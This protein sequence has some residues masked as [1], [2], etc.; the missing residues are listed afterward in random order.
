M[1][2]LYVLDFRMREIG[3]NG[4]PLD[5]LNELVDW[6]IFRPTLS[7]IREKKRKSRASRK[8]IEVVLM[9][10]ILVLQSL[11][12]LSNNVTE[13]QI[14]GRLFFIGFLGL[15][16]GDSV[17]NAKTIWLFRKKFKENGLLSCLFFE[18][19]RFLKNNDFEL[20]KERLLDNT[21]IVSIPRQKN[22]RKE[23]GQIKAED[24]FEDRSANKRGHNDINVQWA[25]KN[26]KSYFEYKN[27]NDY[28]YINNKY[29]WLCKFGVIHASLYN[30]RYL[31]NPLD[32]VFEHNLKKEQK[33]RKKYKK[34]FYRSSFK[35]RKGES[36]FTL[37][38]LMI[39][40]VLLGILAAIALPQYNSYRGR[41][42]ALK[43]VEGAR[44]CAQEMAAICSGNASFTSGSFLSSCSSVPD[45][46]YL[47]N[48]NFIT[49]P[50][51]CSNI[52]A[53]ITGDT[54][55]GTT[56]TA[57]CSGSYNSNITCLL[58]P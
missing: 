45:L 48:E 2:G 4:E 39:V 27:F 23:D 15:F 31:E 57:T 54:Q 10:K 9:F 22:R 13:H 16:I 29:K 32:E 53:A 14:L 58:T 30:N 17:P 51:S 47:K 40:V 5:R 44:A 18:F 20:K 25:K 34:R 36:G 41:A 12:S 19:D 24:E 42:Q 52:Q 55:D 11:Y 35:A 37:V 21:S 1:K 46:P 6:E 38:E 50:S 7:R 43:L 33:I 26:G 3:S 8:P 49:T 56:Y 28:I